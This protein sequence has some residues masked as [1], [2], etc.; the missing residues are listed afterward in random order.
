[1][2]IYLILSILCYAC[3]VYGQ[4]YIPVK[5]MISNYKEQKDVDALKNYDIIYNIEESPEAG[6]FMEQSLL[7]SDLPKPKA[8]RVEWCFEYSSG[9]K[10]ILYLKK[11]YSSKEGKADEISTYKNKLAEKYGKDYLGIPAIWYSGKITVLS[12]PKNL[13]GEIVTKNVI[14]FDIDKGQIISR[15]S[16]NIAKTGTMETTRS[17]RPSLDIKYSPIA[18]TDGCWY[19]NLQYKLDLLEEFVNSKLKKHSSLTTKFGVDILLVTNKKGK[20]SGYLLSPDESMNEEEQALTEQLIKQIS[21]LPRWSFGWLQTI[22]G[23]IFQGRYLKARYS[24]D[25]GWKFEDYLH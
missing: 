12:C 23:S 3:T 13:F 4:H 10:A 17:F 19:S 9:Q 6:I 5:E 16:L 1:M 15:N 22:N 20:A 7:P 21:K 2:K 18:S 8:I 11:T 25:T 14:E 24:S